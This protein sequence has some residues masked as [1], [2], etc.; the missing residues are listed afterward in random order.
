MA[1]VGALPACAP[2]AYSC[3]DDGQCPNGVC[4][5]SGYCSFS[6]ADCDSGRRYG[7][8]AGGGLGGACVPVTDGTTSVA[9]ETTSGDPPTPATSIEG[10]STLEET[11]GGIVSDAA[12]G[13]STSSAAEG[14]SGEG[15]TT[16]FAVERVE[17]GL[18]VLY[19]FDEGQGT[20]VH[21][22]AP[23]EPPIDLELS[24]AGFEWLP[25]ALRFT[26]ETTSM[27]ASTT[28]VTKVNQACQAAEEVTLEAW[29]TPQ[30]LS[31][32]GPPRIVTYSLSASERNFSLLA[33]VD[34]DGADD[35]A[36]RARL[37]VADDTVEALNGAPTLVSPTTAG[38]DN[39][40]AHVV[41]VHETKGAERI[42]VDGAVV[43]AG[44]RPGSLGTWNT[45][46]EMQLALGNELTGERAFDGLLHL[47]AVYCRALSPAE[48][49]QNL[50]AGF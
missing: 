27:A 29:V 32:Q 49:Q 37:R 30:D 13:G 5:A 40:L 23:V 12:S 1:L 28:S 8:F 10:S 43:V 38:A 19:R 48:I 22:T 7:S 9:P 14:S 26:G 35:P 41:F 21:D 6:D 24:G 46:G 16:G 47:V 36:Y 15:T 45:T 18:L 31:L 33:G 42:Y 3:A 20:T 44:E 25:G 4:E 39:T 2:S 50:D 11:S 17:E 34:L